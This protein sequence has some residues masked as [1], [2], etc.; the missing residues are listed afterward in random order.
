MRTTEGLPADKKAAI[1]TMCAVGKR[2]AA[3]CAL[4]KGLGYLH[5]NT[6]RGGMN[7]W[8]AE[9]HPVKIR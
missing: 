9:G 2:S 7:A 1:V 5:V 3:A 8:V 6:S 4:I